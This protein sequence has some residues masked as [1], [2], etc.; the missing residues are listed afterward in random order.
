MTSVERWSALAPLAVACVTAV[1]SCRPREHASAPN[2]K[3]SASGAARTDAALDD[4]VM[5]AEYAR[6]EAAVPADALTSREARVRRV[7]ARALA[8]IADDRVAAGLQ[9]GLGDEDPEVVAWSAYGLGY[10][11]RG[12][13]E[14]VRRLVARAASLPESADPVRDGLSPTAAIADAI[15]RCGGAAVERTLVAWLDGPKVRSRAAA[16]ALGRLAADRHRLSDEAIVALLDAAAVSEADGA[17]LYPLSRLE[18]LSD[19]ASKRL[20]DVARGAIKAGGEART[21]AIRALGSAGEPA[22]SVLGDALADQ[23]FSSADRCA[24]AVALGRIGAGAKPVLAQALARFVGTDKVLDDRFMASH[25]A[26]LEA[27]LATPLWP[28]AEARAPL[29]RLAEAPLGDS[30][31]PSLRRRIVALRCGAAS[32]LAGSASRSARLVACDPDAGGRAGALATLRVLDRGKLTGSRFDAWEKLASHADPGVR[33]AALGLVPTHPEMPAVI[34]LLAR[35]IVGAEPGIAAQAAR[36]VALEPRRAA[37]GSLLDAPR[38]SGPAPEP[39][40]S[41]SPK[42]VEALAHAMDAERPPDEIEAR[43]AFMDAA[44]ALG[45]LSLKSRVE[46]YCASANVTLRT[47]AERALARFGQS[48][49]ACP[50]AKAPDARRFDGAVPHPAAVTLTFQTDAG[51]L[52]L[53][54]D[55]TDAPLAVDR[56]TSL[57]R[58]GFYDGIRIHRVTPG[59]VAQFGDP[60]GDGSGGAGKPPLPCETSPTEFSAFSVGVALS[61]RDTGS[62]QIFVTLAPEPY[63]DGDYA[64]IGRAGSEWARAAEGDVIQR[65]EV[66]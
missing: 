8:R 13:E 26:P 42:I 36:V 43:V 29:S 24:A 16:L 6:D 5:T 27:V 46:R 38:P 39:D 60:V 18:A 40:E 20:V 54:L 41:A 31:S 45:N 66:R 25:L 30:P 34:D 10:I 50:A 3:P 57:A 62:S 58:A 53:A 23:S 14:T 32:A 19:S 55:P 1:A 44:A 9:K 2:P 65:V 17:T 56:V 61:G 51:P 35:S 12:S 64:L 47:R 7:A 63:L 21:F 22:A 49:Q 37:R 28:N 59:F 48:A 11:C 15:A 4:R 52:T 33:R